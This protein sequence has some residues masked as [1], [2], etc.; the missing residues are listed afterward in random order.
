MVNSFEGLAQR[1]RN[2]WMAA[3]GLRLGR[4]DTRT[5]TNSEGGSGKVKMPR[6]PLTWTTTGARTAG[7]RKTG[8]R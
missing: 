7:G 8:D 5:T 4:C 6:A 2:L 1:I 3:L